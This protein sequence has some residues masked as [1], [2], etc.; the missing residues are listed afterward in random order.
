[1]IPDG[2]A[3]FTRGM[4][5]SCVREQE[6]GF[7]ERSW[8]Y[9]M[10]FNKVIGMTNWIDFRDGQVDIYR[11]TPYLVRKG[12]KLVLEYSTPSISVW[13]DMTTRL[14]WLVLV[15]QVKLTGEQPFLF[16]ILNAELFTIPQTR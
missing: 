13:M 10:V 4:G 14:V 2:A 3:L 6:R 9:S 12:S 5:M 15:H 16:H 11:A 7:G 8:R 1:M